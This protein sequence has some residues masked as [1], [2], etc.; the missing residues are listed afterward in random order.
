MNNHEWT[1]KHIQWVTKAKLTQRSRLLW[2]VDRCIVAKEIFV[3]KDTRMK[4]NPKPPTYLRTNPSTH[5]PTYPPTYLPIFLSNEL[6]GIRTWNF[7][8]NFT[9]SVPSRTTASNLH[10]ETCLLMI[11]HLNRLG[12]RCPIKILYAF[13]FYP[14]VLYYQLTVLPLRKYHNNQKDRLLQ[15]SG[16]TFF[17]NASSVYLVYSQILWTIKQS[18]LSDNIEGNS[19]D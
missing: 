6:S 12:F 4:Q 3:L 2:N 18:T 11:Y 15:V 1:R 14:Y 16:N 17:N 7:K 19:L 8:T 10:E 13:L 5:P 9:H